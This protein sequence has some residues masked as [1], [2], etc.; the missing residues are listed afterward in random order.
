MPDLIRLESVYFDHGYW[1][2]LRQ[3]A[4]L[5]AVR[6]AQ[7]ES[8]FQA[9]AHEQR[10]LLQRFEDALKPALVGLASPEAMEHLEQTVGGHVLL[11]G[12][13][14]YSM[15]LLAAAGM[16]IFGP[17][18]ALPPDAANRNP[19]MLVLP[20]LS[21]TSRAPQGVFGF[22]SKLMNQLAT[23]QEARLDD[24]QS[25]LNQLLKRLK[26]S[27]PAGV[28]TLKFLQAADAL[29]IP[30]RHVAN[31]VY[32]F[33]WGRRARWLDSSFTDITP[34]ISSNLARD[35]SACAKVLQDAGLPAPLHELVSSADQAQKVAQSLGYPVVVK[36]AN[37][38]GGQGVFAG[39]RTPQAVERAYGEA[40]KLSRR[41]LVEQFVVGQ[42]YRLQ[43]YQGEVFWVVHRRPACVCGDGEH[44]VSELVAMI[45][46]QRQQA[47]RAASHDHMAEVGYVSIALDD[48]ALEW[49]GYQD[50][51]PEAVPA[52]GQVVR[53]RGAANVGMGGTREGVPLEQVH[54]DNLKMV[55]QAA[56]CL[57]LDLA[58]IDLLVPDISQSWKVT[59]GA[60][61][62]VNAQ[63]Q[64]SGHLQQLLLPKIV[65]G[66]GR[67]PVIGLCLS[68]TAWS[69]ETAVHRAVA[70]AGAHL[71]WASSVE[72][73]R[74]ALVNPSVDAVIW[75]IAKPAQHVSSLP[76]DAL[77]VLV[78]PGNSAGDFPAADQFE[79]KYPRL[80]S[81][82]QSVW[83]VGGKVQSAHSISTQELS[84]AL[85]RHV[86]ASTLIE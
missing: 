51:T 43:V 17:P 35:K 41:V 59:G 63:P 54:P 3:P 74:E 53:L 46:A 30:W 56:Q 16:P 18:L 75:R 50:L 7:G 84:A 29:N 42:D 85:V 86:L 9:Q 15:V 32:Q 48:E 8:S 80:F 83:T 78:L 62:E 71:V 81:A 14:R 77:D 31:N 82:S 61:C 11:A 67:I 1:A 55:V 38:D 66:Q 73:L 47:P 10:L 22:V 20:A 58:G 4:V 44:S 65:M 34:S 57:R 69:D 2:H 79:K 33:G 21:R 28:N 45:N 19:W 76:V 39:L 6:V 12:L 25:G 70:K 49:L 23:G 24:I 26:A 36:P 40:S 68:A 13:L 64:L 27:A 52:L 72:M 37:L 5:L 60:I